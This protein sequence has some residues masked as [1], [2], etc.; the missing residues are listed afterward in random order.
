MQDEIERLDEILA[1]ARKVE[2]ETKIGRLVELIESRLPAG[3]SVLL[4]TEY[5]A[6]QALVLSALESRFGPA[7]P[8]SSTARKSWSSRATTVRSG[9]CNILATPL[10]RF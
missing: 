2:T 9:C 7:A 6:T 3:E 5:K 4:F 10:R 8:V 1:L